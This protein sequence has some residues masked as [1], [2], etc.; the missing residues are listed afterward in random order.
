MRAI[1]KIAIPN[2][3]EI[4]VRII[5]ACQEMGIKTVLL[6]SAADRN[7]KATRISNE[8]ICIGPAEPLKSYLNIKAIITAALSVQADAIH[9]GYGFLSESSQLASACKNNGLIFIGPSTNQLELFGDK[10]LTRQKAQAYGIPV[11][12]ANLK[13]QLRC[14]QAIGFPVIIKAAHGGGGRGLRVVHLEKDWNESLAAA[15]REVKNA[16]GSEEIFIEK[17]LPAA[18]HIEVQVFADASG[19]VH[20]LFDRNCSIQRNHQK[21]IEEAPAESVPLTIRQKMK[22]AALDLMCSVGYQQAGTVEFLYQEDKFYFMEV[23]PR[24]QVECPVTE[25]ILGVDLVKA[26][27]LTAAGH[28]PFINKSLKPKGHSIQCRI[29][30]EDMQKQ[31]PTFGCLGSCVFPYG[32]GRRVDIGFESGDEISEFYDSMI[33]K[34]IVWDE[35]RIRALK[36]MK[37]ALS[38]T[39]IFGVKTNVSFLQDLLS[40]HQFVASQ[41]NTRF[42]QEVFLKSWQEKGVNDL[43]PQVVRFDFRC[44][45]YTK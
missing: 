24:L 36:R 20:Y 31:V 30:A 42:V 45:F 33:G 26:Q 18:Q 2:R 5:T 13:C 19:E 37:I 12:P 6:Y 16:F 27:I 41:I 8:K 23:N 9:P 34:I 14:A 28:F 7:S 44:I 17:Y 43:D 10:A 40:H 11:L 3:G 22:K 15:K 32:A 21:I 1:R 4:A 39:I 29:Y 25:M 35:N 38:E